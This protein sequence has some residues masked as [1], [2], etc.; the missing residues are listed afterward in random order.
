MLEGWRSL[1]CSPVELRIH[2]TLRCGQA[3]RWVRVS[4]DEYAGV[5]GQRVVLLKQTGINLM[6]LIPYS[7]VAAMLYLSVIPPLW[8]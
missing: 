6:Q 2:H 5:L 1:G 7:I 3:F 8:I 4:E